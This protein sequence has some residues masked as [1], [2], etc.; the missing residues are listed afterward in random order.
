MEF[1]VLSNFQIFLIIISITALI[2][3]VLV[4]NR[5]K[6]IPTDTEAFNYAL[7]ALVDGDK[8]KAYNLLRDIISK[9]SNNIDAFL[10][11]GDIVREKD[12]KQAI[13][14]HQT[15][16]LRPQI[17]KEKK[18]EAHKALAKDFFKDENIIR[19]ENELNNILSIDSSNKFA[20]RKLKNIATENKNWKVA[21]KLEKKLMKID[22]DHKKNDES[23]LNYY[24][25]MDYKSKDN[26]KNYVYYLEKSA[27]SEN[28]YPDSVLEL[29]NHNKSNAELAISY[30]KLYAKHMPSQ[31]T[32]AYNKI[33]NILFDS[34]K[35]DE[36]ENLY[37]SLLET[38]FDGFA[39]NRLI[40]ILLE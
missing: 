30:Y 11:L 10:L 33:E 20:L 35:Y 6:N 31:R 8:E 16:V 38:D 19:A 7:K 27:T 21:L 22:V 5:S 17:S 3:F 39:L 32:V 12:V 14:I 4:N 26:I 29:A 18:I 13:K 40:D 36:V 2:I 37:R 34:Q 28:I 15:I 9:D 1:L 23:M 25:A 24:I